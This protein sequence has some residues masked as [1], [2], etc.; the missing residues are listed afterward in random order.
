MEE[1]EPPALRGATC[2][3]LSMANIRM[4]QR[5]P[6]DS[7]CHRLAPLSMDWAMWPYR[8]IWRVSRCPRVSDRGP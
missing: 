2:T 8:F 5:T 3:C 1:E 7:N 4:D 6:G